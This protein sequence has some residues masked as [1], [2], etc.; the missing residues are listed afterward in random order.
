MAISPQRPLFLLL[1]LSTKYEDTNLERFLQVKERKSRLNILLL[2][3]LQTTMLTNIVE[4]CVRWE[5]WA[6]QAV[7][8]GELATPSKQAKS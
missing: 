5:V 6:G 3:P 4:D 2:V 8:A 7:Q 1:D